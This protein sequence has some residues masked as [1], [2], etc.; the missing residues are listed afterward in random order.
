MADSMIMFGVTA[1][2]FV[3]LAAI[4]FGAR[5]KRYRSGYT[6]SGGHAETK[7]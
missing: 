4:V 3:F 2:I 7:E 5:A 1:G 6:T